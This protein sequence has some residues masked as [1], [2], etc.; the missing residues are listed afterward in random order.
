MPATPSNCGETLKPGLTK[1]R[2][3][4]AFVAEDNDLGYGNSSPRIGS[5]AAKPHTQASPS[6]ERTGRGAVHRLDGGG[7]GFPL[8]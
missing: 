4:R 3:E 6:G 5:S 1:H 8:H 2:P 7:R